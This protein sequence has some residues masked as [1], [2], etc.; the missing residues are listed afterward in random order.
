MKRQKLRWR[1][2]RR[3][4]K[5]ILRTGIAVLGI[6]IVTNVV[7]WAVYRNRTYPHTKVMQTSIGSVAYGELSAKVSNLN[8]LPEKLTFSHGQ[9]KA[10]A[11]L[12]DLGI[13]KDVDRTTKSADTQRSWLPII[14][15]FKT[16]ELQAP[17]TIDNQKLSSKAEELA[18]ALRADPVNAHLVL[19][20]TSVSIENAKDGYSLDQNGL[21][22]SILQSLDK[23][24]TT[25]DPATNSIKP[26]VQAADLKSQKADLEA[27][28]K[29]AI[30]YTYAG[31]SKQASS[32]DIA[33]WYVPSGET[34]AASPEK[35]QAYITTVGQGFGIRVKDL[36]GVANTT[37]QSLSKKQ[38][39][40]QTLVQQVALKTFTYCVAAKG[41]DASNI[42]GLKAKLKETYGS[43]RGWSVDGLIEYQEVPSGCN[44]T[45]WL[46]AASLMPSFG[47][48]CD[49]MWSC[50][51]GPN[52]VINF[53]RWQNA[54]P[55]WNQMGGTLDEYRHM[56]INHETG[57]WLGFDHAHCPGPG[58]QAPVM[59]QQSIDLQ[60]CT[61][62]A[63]PSAGEIA[64]LRQRQGI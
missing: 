25:V 31:K 58:Q 8:L 18:K 19:S 43:S 10:E 38:P 27:Q 6:F 35:I 51:V 24:K 20:N 61:F 5:I 11:S 15:L 7:L 44:F 39:L 9:Q 2:S 53:D 23:G 63:W 26:K 16:P 41:V 36:G 56:V 55:A 13:S 22:R 59:Q 62:S 48:I 33:S 28:L 29:T 21:Q 57:H 32:A 42:P 4:R 50:R 64:E 37:A 60:G 52:V 3:T 45:V 49:S 12:T 17:V 14:N 54:S 1:L 40:N 46:T 30:T 47:A 34:Y